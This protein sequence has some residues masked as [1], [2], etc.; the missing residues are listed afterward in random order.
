MQQMDLPLEQDTLARQYNE[1][2]G[3]YE[4]SKLWTDADYYD[5]RAAWVKEAELWL[6]NQEAIEK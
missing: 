4:V 2:L 1:E 3:I 6:A 5:G